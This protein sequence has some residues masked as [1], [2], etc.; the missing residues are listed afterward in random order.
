MQLRR[1]AIKQ[2]GD[3][4]VYLGA[5]DEMVVVQ[6]EHQGSLGR[7]QFVD[8][9]GEHVTQHVGAGRVQPPQGG[10]AR[11]RARLVRGEQQVPPEA[12]GVVVAVVERDPARSDIIPGQPV[13]HDRALAPPGRRHDQGQGQRSPLAQQV[14]QP[15]ALHGL[16]PEGRP[17]QLGRDHDLGSA[18]RH[19][20]PPPLPQRHPALLSC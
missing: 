4:R 15:L 5:G 2:R 6:H 17:E 19:P 9:R 1:G 8:E 10:G 11:G 3:R 7:R 18:S 20:T 16:L 14:I 12:L 13:G